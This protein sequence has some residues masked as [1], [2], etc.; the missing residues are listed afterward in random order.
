M[1]VSYLDGVAQLN[2]QNSVWGGNIPKYDGDTKITIADAPAGNTDIQIIW[3]V[4]TGMEKWS[5]TGTLLIADRILLTNVSWNGLVAAG[6][7]DGVTVHLKG[8]PYRCYLL[9]V[10]SQSNVPNA[11]DDALDPTTND[12]DICIGERFSPEAR[13]RRNMICTV[14][15]AGA[16]RPAAGITARPAVG[17]RTLVSVRHLNL[18]KLTTCR[19]HSNAMQRPKF[20][21]LS[22]MSVLLCSSLLS[23]CKREIWVRTTSGLSAK[24][25]AMSCSTV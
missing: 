12:N 4:I 22:M 20:L 13:I 17:T 18:R 6:F 8:H 11:W 2:P 16:I 23:W 19:W 5:R 14:R 1:G 25:N 7:A 9:S 21:K 15:T 24:T 3:N 10:G